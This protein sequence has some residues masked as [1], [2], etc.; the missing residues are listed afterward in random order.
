ML[1]KN[2]PVI[3]KNF[4][5]PKF[6]PF[7]IFQA[8]PAPV[9]PL[10]DDELILLAFDIAVEHAVENPDWPL[11]VFGFLK[12]CQN[13]AEKYRIEA[14][15]SQAV[16]VEKLCERLRYGPMAEAL[17]YEMGEYEHRRI[18]GAFS[19]PCAMIKV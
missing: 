7:S 5:G 2:F 3:L 1:N 18:K 15:V 6:E 19:Y 16:T 4:N 17:V 10:A 11:D 13:R 9:A 12:N 14:K 8:S